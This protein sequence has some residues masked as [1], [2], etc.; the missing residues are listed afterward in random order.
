MLLARASALFGVLSLAFAAFLQN[1]VHGFQGPFSSYNAPGQQIFIYFSPVIPLCL[2][3]FIFDPLLRGGGSS[4]QLLQLVLRLGSKAFQNHTW[5]W[6]KTAQLSPQTS[7]VR[8]WR[9]APAVRVLT[10]QVVLPKGNIT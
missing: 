2:Q 5:H 1:P 10:A 7:A 8:A 4:P 3:D 6:L 9:A